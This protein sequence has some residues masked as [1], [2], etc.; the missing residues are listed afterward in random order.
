M[1]IRSKSNRQRRLSTKSRQRN[2]TRELRLKGFVAA[3]EGYD[4]PRQPAG[5]G[6]QWAF[7]PRTTAIYERGLSQGMAHRHTLAHERVRNMAVYHHVMG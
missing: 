6:M 3:R 4:M 5:E 1:S 7:V 2:Q